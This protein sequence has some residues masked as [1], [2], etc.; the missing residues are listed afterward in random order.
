MQLTGRLAVRVVF[1]FMLEA[2]GDWL[3]DRLFLESAG[4]NVELAGA[5]LLLA[6]CGLL[7]LTLPLPAWRFFDE[8]GRRG[9]LCEAEGRLGGGEARSREE[10]PKQPIAGRSAT[11]I[12]MSHSDSDDGTGRR[13]RLDWATRTW[14]CEGRSSN[15]P[16]GAD[17]QGHKWFPGRSVYCTER[18][19]G[20]VLVTGVQWCA[21]IKSLLSNGS[22]TLLRF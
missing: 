15:R 3:A 9:S 10:K 2:A 21:A 1:E 4:A 7:P 13:A 16:K 17:L 11:R 22:K 18:T 6:S 5:L 19:M 14:K 12:A 8:E 20:T